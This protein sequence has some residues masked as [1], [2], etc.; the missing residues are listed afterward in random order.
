METLNVEYPDTN[1]Q[2]FA[3]YPASVLTQISEV[4]SLKLL[5]KSLVIKQMLTPFFPMLKDIVELHFYST[6]FLGHP[7]GRTDPLKGID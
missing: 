3:I 4:T 7:Y 1:P 6:V 2:F 5:E